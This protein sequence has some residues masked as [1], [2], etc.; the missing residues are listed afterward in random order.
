MGKAGAWGGEQ[1]GLGTGLCCHCP[2][3]WPV[4]GPTLHWH[5]LA[6]LKGWM[7]GQGTWD[8]PRAA[9]QSPGSTVGRLSRPDTLV[10]PGLHF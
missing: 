1:P 7:W 3:R 5:S 4:T 9:S 10:S 2:F 8:T 6:L